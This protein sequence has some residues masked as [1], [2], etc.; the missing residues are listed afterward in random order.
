MNAAGCNSLGPAWGDFSHGNTPIR[1]C[2]LERP[3]LCICSGSRHFG[4][5]VGMKMSHQLVC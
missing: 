3:K 4:Q 2:K 5:S 1:A